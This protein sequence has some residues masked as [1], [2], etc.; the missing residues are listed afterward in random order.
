MCVCVCVCV[1]VFESLP[2]Q[3]PVENGGRELVHC[4]FES[5]KMRCLIF[6]FNF[7]EGHLFVCDTS[8]IQ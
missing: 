3:L 5:V 4:T 1:C 6:N 8:N 2:Q 7:L